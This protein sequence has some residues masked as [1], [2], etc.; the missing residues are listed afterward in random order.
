[1]IV[2]GVEITAF[3][4]DKMRDGGNAAKKTRDSIRNRKYYAANRERIRE[5]RNRRYQEQK[6]DPEFVEKNRES[7]RLYRRLHREEINA[8]RRDRYQRKKLEKQQERQ[9]LEEP[10]K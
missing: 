4:I 1:M 5:R 9:R 10:L 2:E 7:S 8:R 6:D 3:D